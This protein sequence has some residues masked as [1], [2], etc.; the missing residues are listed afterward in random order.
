M[1][2]D[3]ISVY[4]GPNVHAREAVIRLQLDVR[5]SYAET[6]MELGADVIDRLAAV[7][8]G[9]A[10]YK[11][12]MTPHEYVTKVIAGE[13]YDSTLSFQLKMGFRVRGLLQNYLEDSAS[14]NWATL[15]EWLNE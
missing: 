7:L 10:R 9:L 11:Q 2:I 6:L 1:N 4:V 13:L 14:D 12:T 8:P 5:P 15:I 3:S